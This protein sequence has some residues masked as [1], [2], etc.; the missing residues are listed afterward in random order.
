ME[1]MQADADAGDA[2]MVNSGKLAPPPTLLSHS[3]EAGVVGFLHRLNS[4][5]L[6]T[7]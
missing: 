1:A 2:R 4:Q 6:R 5:L 7:G 3:V